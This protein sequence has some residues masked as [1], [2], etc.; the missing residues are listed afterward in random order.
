MGLRGARA[1]ALS[2]KNGAGR[3]TGS[4]PD[5]S[6]SVDMVRAFLVGNETALRALCRLDAWDNSPCVDFDADPAAVRTE[7]DR[8][9]LV[10]R[11]RIIA[12]IGRRG[13]FQ[14]SALDDQNEARAAKAWERLGKVAEA[15]G[16]PE[17]TWA[18]IRHRAGWTE[19]EANDRA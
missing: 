9:A 1:H 17:D 12:T 19:E 5:E 6:V 11:R 15:V 13:H 4:F 14:F 8:R 18:E 3:K 2:E 7:G 16:V 10:Y